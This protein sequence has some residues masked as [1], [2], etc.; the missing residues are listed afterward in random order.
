MTSRDLVIFRSVDELVQYINSKIEE[1]SKKVEEYSKLAEEVKSFAEYAKTLRE[2]LEKAL[3]KEV[4]FTSELEVMGFRLVV[5]ARPIDEYEVLSDVLN[6][7]TERMKVLIRF[8]EAILPLLE[9][10]RE[11]GRKFLVYLV[12]ENEVPVKL[13]IKET[14]IRT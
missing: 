2:F 10:L 13:L 12:L 3:G 5:D 11:S 9:K 8:R 14:E 7:L 1:I 4:K 6:S